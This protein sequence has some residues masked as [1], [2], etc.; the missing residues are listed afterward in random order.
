MSTAT[1]LPPPLGGGRNHDRFVRDPYADPSGSPGTARPAGP[2]T[3]PARQDVAAAKQE[4]R[5]LTSELDRL[6][7][8]LCDVEISEEWLTS[9]AHHPATRNRPI[10]SFTGAEP[11]HPSLL[12]DFTD[13]EPDV[14]YGSPTTSSTAAARGAR[15]H[16]RNHRNVRWGHA[17]PTVD[18]F[19]SA[20]RAARTR[21][22]SS[23]RRD[24]SQGVGLAAGH[25]RNRPKA[26]E[27]PRWTDD[28]GR[29]GPGERRCTHR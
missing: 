4:V 9:V 16:F 3:N 8:Q 12:D 15:V 29:L 6:N 25:H 7:R 17:S 1:F 23:C 28:C 24:G 5:R 26:A 10:R 2:D 11:W 19:R 18:R 21:R 22:S 13:I 14:A 27:L 20:P